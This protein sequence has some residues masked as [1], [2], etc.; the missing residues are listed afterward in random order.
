MS[1]SRHQKESWE[2]EAILRSVYNCYMEIRILEQPGYEKV[3][4]AKDPSTGLRALIAVHNTRLGPGLGGIRMQAYASEQEAL[5]DVLRL[6]RGMTYKSASVDLK[7]GGGKAVIIGDPAQDKTP[8]LFQR[9]GEFINT[10]QGTYY[11]AKD[12]GVTTEDLLEVVKTTSYVTGLPSG[13]GDPSYLTAQGVLAGIQSAAQFKLGTSNLD[14]LHVVIQGLGHVGY[15]LAKLLHFSG[16]R[17]TVSDIYAPAAQKAVSE[18]G[19]EAVSEKE[20]FHVAADVFSP[21]ALGGILNAATIP[22][23]KAAIVAGAAN[24]QL[25]DEEKDGDLLLKKNILYAPDYMINA[26][27]VINIYVIDILKEKHPERWLVKIRDNLQK[28]FETSKEE[29]VSTAHAANLL[30]EKKLF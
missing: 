5:T 11:S 8:A 28:V 12:A 22:R 29:K 25:W 30:T 16:A 1:S 19:A 20:I 10:F 15:S 3:A 27:G 18:F 17:L 26:G 2:V 7:L 13:S 21:C 9:M 24:N 23:L 4:I 6:A 14:G